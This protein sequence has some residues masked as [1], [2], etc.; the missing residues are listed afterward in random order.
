MENLPFDYS[1]DL[2]GGEITGVGLTNI[3]WV[4]LTLAFA[5][6]FIF[7]LILLFHWNRYGIGKISVWSTEVI[8]IFGVIF[9]V[10]GAFASL[11]LI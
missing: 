3:L 4:V 9:L 1:I 5:I 10:L 11:M 6:S 8:Y 2:P 7:S